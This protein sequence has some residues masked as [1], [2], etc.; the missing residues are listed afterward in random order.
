[1]VMRIIS[2]IIGLPLLVFFVTN[3]SYYLWAVML[4]ISIIG[5]V[6]FYSAVQKKFL[7]IHFIGYLFAVIYFCSLI[8]YSSHTI[9]LLFISPLF[10]IVLLIFS[11]FNFNKINIFDCAVTLLGFYYI[12]VLLSFIYLVREHSF[13]QLFVWLIFICAWGCD[14]GAYFVGILFGKHKLAPELSPK[15]TIEGAIGGVAFATIIALIYGF[16]I[17]TFFAFNEFNITLSCTIIGLVGSV[18]AQLGDLSASAVKRYTSIKDFGNIIPGHGGI[19]DRFDSI[20][21]TAPGVFFA[22]VFMFGL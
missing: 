8:N 9:N 7:S 10:I 6:E 15:K 13:G 19:L 3:G 4:G 14:T 17:S 20:L 5:M 12:P 11:I 2:S 18:F 21:L 16:T 1:M 22:M